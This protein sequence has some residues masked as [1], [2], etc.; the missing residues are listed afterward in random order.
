[1]PKDLNSRTE[2][3]NTNN[4]GNEKKNKNKTAV[5]VIDKLGLVETKN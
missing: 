1:M 3:S 5:R 2:N 4:N